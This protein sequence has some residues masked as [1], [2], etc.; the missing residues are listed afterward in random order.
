MKEDLIKKLDKEKQNLI[1]EINKLTKEN[2]EQKII[3]EKLMNEND[4][5]KEENIKIN[6]SLN[7]MLKGN[8]SEVELFELDNIGGLNF[9]VDIESINDGQIE[10][11]DDIKESLN[12]EDKEEK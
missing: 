7:E 4:N 8:K 3:N 12:Q 2:N 10:K 1:E 5:L 6:N 11:I 9:N